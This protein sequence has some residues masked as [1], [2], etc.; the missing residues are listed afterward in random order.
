[1]LNGLSFMPIRPFLWIEY[2]TIVLKKYD[3]FRKKLESQDRFRILNIKDNR[4]NECL[5]KIQ[6]I[7]KSTVFDCSPQEIAGNDQFLE[8][9]SKKDIRTIVYFATQEIK[10]PRYKLLT[11]DV[12][13]NR[14]IKIY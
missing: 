7:G 3:V 10:K 5:F 1:M 6:V 14:S 12:Q 4:W 9:F 8:G 13:E 2:L 11:Q